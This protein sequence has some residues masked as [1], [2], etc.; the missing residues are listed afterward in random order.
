MCWFQDSLWDNSSSHCMRSYTIHRRVNSGTDSNS[1]SLCLRLSGEDLLTIDLWLNKTSTHNIINQRDLEI[2]WCLKQ[3]HVN[4]HTHPS[5]WDGGNEDEFRLRFS[6][7]GTVS[8]VVSWCPPIGGFQ[9]RIRLR[10]L[11]H[12]TLFNGMCVSKLVCLLSC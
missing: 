10:M 4:T 6:I 8:V 5:Q 9:T 12:F 7:A 2:S 11:L 1:V 3:V